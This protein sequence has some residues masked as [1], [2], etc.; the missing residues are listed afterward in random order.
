MLGFLFR[1]VLSV[2]FDFIFISGASAVC[3]EGEVS[4]FGEV[5]GVQE[6]K[7]GKKGDFSS[8]GLKC[9]FLLF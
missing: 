5:T 7:Q 1:F 6:Q 9:K 4:D 3:A 8:P 2:W